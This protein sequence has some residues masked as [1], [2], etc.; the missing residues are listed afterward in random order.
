MNLSHTR[1]LNICSSTPVGWWQLFLSP[2]KP[3]HLGYHTLLFE[4]QLDYIHPVWE[5]VPGFLPLD[6][7]RIYLRKKYL[8]ETNKHIFTEPHKWTRCP[9]SAW[10]AGGGGGS[11]KMKDLEQ[12]AQ[13]R[14]LNKHSP[15]KPTSWFSKRQQ[16]ILT[17]NDTSWIWK[18]NVHQ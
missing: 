2:C 6:G 7:F 17:F 10:R 1:A 15:N 16:N 18:P 12:P 8:P 3:S 11:Q 5:G 4:K 9:N 14:R 13:T